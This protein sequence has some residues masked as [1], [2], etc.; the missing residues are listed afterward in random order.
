MDK[1]YVFCDNPRKELRLLAVGLVSIYCMEMEN[2]LDN[3]PDISIHFLA[4]SEG[5]TDEIGEAYE[6]SGPKKEEFYQ[7]I[8]KMNAKFKRDNFIEYA[9]N[10]WQ[11][12]KADFI[13]LIPDNEYKIFQLKKPN[14]N[15]INA[16]LTPE[17][18]REI[19]NSL[20]INIVKE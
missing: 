7:I 18:C 17:N 12:R 2:Y 6:Y 16:I 19:M 8:D 5:R 4:W 3:Y 10:Y 9:I 1:L 13:N 20:I 15:E 14:K 11:K